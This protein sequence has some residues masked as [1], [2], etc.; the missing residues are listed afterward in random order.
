MIKN[1]ERIEKWEN[2]RDFSFS[3]LC[4]VSGGKVEGWKKMSLYKFTHILLLKKWCIIFFLSGEQQKKKKFNHLNLLK[5][6][7][8]A[9]KKN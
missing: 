7:N 9:Q 4:L 5:N 3:H 1:R 2:R 6:K 8:Y